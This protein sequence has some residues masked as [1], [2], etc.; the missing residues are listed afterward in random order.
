MIAG[1]PNAGRTLATIA[2]A[3]FIAMI[4]ISAVVAVRK[5]AAP[6]N[7]PPLHPSLISVD[8]IL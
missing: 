1:N 3:I 5:R 4:L 2:I 6:S 7:E 8:W